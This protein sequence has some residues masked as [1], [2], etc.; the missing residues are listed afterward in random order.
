MTQLAVL[1]KTGSP[2][3]QR[4]AKAIMP[5]RKDSHRLLVTLLLANMAINESKFT[6]TPCQDFC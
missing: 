3:Q 5:I 2:K 4:Q 6:H 1:E